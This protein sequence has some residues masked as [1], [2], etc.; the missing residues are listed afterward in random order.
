MTSVIILLSII[1][2][3]LYG[4]ARH[5]ARIELNTRRGN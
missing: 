4:I 3:Q 1:V 2:L 5:L